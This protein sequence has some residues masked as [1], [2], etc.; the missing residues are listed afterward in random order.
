[1]GCLGKK[2]SYVAYNPNFFVKTNGAHY[3]PK[4]DA[5]SPNSPQ[6]PFPSPSPVLRLL[7]VRLADLPADASR[8]VV[9]PRSPVD[10][11]QPNPAHEPLLRQHQDRQDAHVEQSRGEVVG[12][13]RAGEEAEDGGD[14]DEE[15]VGVVA[16]L[17]GVLAVQDLGTLFLGW[18]LR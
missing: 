18:G 13:G 15:S 1:M 2:C 12:G 14:E 7:K 8:P 10:P 16:A 3:F 5:P 17:D 4:F 9:D 6:E 11:Q